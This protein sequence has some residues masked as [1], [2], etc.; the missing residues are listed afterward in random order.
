MIQD[1]GIRNL[2]NVP[3]YK[4]LTIAEGTLMTDKKE[5]DRPKQDARREIILKIGVN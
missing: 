4:C 1:N 2:N 5:N 3:I